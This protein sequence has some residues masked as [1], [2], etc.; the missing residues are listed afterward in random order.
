MKLSSVRVRTKAEAMS[1]K[2]KVYVWMMGVGQQRDVT[3]EDKDRVPY[4]LSLNDY[5]LPGLHSPLIR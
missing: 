3:L 2:F 4:Q 1:A 5:P